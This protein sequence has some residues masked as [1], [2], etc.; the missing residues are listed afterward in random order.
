MIRDRFAP[1]P[2]G[3]VHIGSL[4]T[5]LYN[6]LYAK[7]NGG[8]FLLR[9]EDTDRTRYQ[10]GAVETL[11]NALYTTGVIPDEGL[12]L[13]N[14]TPAQKGAFGPYIQSERLPVY[15]NYIKTLLDSGDAYYCFCTKER[16][17]ALREAQREAG[18]TPRYDGHCRDLS[19]EEIDARIAAGEPYVIRLKLP[20][21]REITFHDAVRGDVTINTDDL[22][23]QVLIKADGFPTYHFAVV[24]D[25]HDMEITHVIRG[26]EWLPSTPKHVY[27]YERMNWQAPEYVHLP[28]ILNADHKKLSKRQGDVSVSDFFD[29]G[30]LPEALVNYLA[31][32]GW[33]PEGDREI[34]SLD[35][36]VDAFDLSRVNKSGAVFDRDKL[37]WMNA[38]Y[39]RAMQPEDLKEAL[40]PFLKTAG[41]ELD[42]SRFDTAVP[43]LQERIE[44]LAQAPEIIE[45]MLNADFLPETDEE[46]EI[47]AAPQTPI[48]RKALIEKFTELDEFTPGT[49][50]PVFKAI[51]KEYKADKIKGKML[52]MP[53]R[54]MITGEMHG[55][56]LAAIIAFLGKEEVLRRLERAES[57]AG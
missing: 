57:F 44:Y 21:D 47:L 16:L 11:L 41:I 13:E 28:N 50:Q 45:E 12:V 17:D 43:V 23:D 54:I 15:Q 26:E 40:R 55:P 7:K 2:T 56:D 36:L 27:L 52:Y 19:K 22:D 31:L 30:Y 34:F 39:I 4:R 1:S 53:A 8:A 49:V 10:E 37:N 6:Y 51:Q 42:E 33:S 9:L 48:L 18:E 20:A 35:E 29:K 25:D 46:K 38:Q 24:C 5:A 32:L 3:D 14:G